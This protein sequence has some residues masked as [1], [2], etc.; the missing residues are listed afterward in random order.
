LAVSI[1]PFWSP[2]EFSTF[3]VLLTYCTV[4]QSTSTSVTTTTADAL[5]NQIDELESLNPDS[6]II[7]LGDLNHLS[8]NLPNYHQQVSCATRADR[9]LDKCYLKL[10]DAYKSYKLPRLGNSDHHPI[11]L[12]PKYQP[13]SRSNRTVNSISARNWSKDNID[14][15]ISTLETTD[16]PILSGGDEAGVD[17]QAEILTSYLSFCYETCIPTFQITLRHDKP[18]MNREIRALLAARHSALSTHDH[19]KMHHIKS[20]LQCKIRKAKRDYAKRVE[21]SFNTS[22]RHS[23]KRLKSMLRMNKQE[24]TCNVPPDLLNQF[25]SRFEKELPSPQ[26]PSTCSDNLP[27]FNVDDVTKALVCSGINKSCGPDGI[28]GKLLR[29]AAQ[30]IAEPLCSLF[31]KCIQEGIFPKIW[32][33]SNIVPV[34]KH[35]QASA[36]KDY[37]PVALT[38]LV[39]KTFEKLLLKFIR[40]TLTDDFQFAYRPHRGTEDALAHLLDIVTEHLDRNPRG[41]ARCLFIDFTSAFNTISPSILINE[42]LNKGLHQNI[43][44]LI[45]SFLT[46]RSQSVVTTEGSSSSIF[47]SV[48][49]PQGCVLSPLLFTIYIQHIP[50]PEATNY[51]V[52]KYADDIVY[53]ELLNKDQQST[54]S[55]TANDMASWCARNELVLNASK[56]KDLC[57][58]NLRFN[59][60]CD[61]IVI[62]GTA[63]EKVESFKY[64]GT[65]LHCKLNFQQNTEVV[66]NKARKRL[67]IMKQLSALGTS[68]PIRKMCYTTFIECLFKYHI[69]TIYGH[70][71]TSCCKSVDKVIRLAGYLAQ[72]SFQDLES[73]YNSCFKTRC[74]RMFMSEQEPLFD[75]DRLPSGR[76]RAIKYRVGIRGKCFRALCIKLLNQVL[77]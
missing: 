54:L 25:Y 16:W 45:Y 8:I 47:T 35:N 5:N 46:E 11:V 72:C 56:T 34:P 73:I 14:R 43:V 77:F 18:W 33:K 59:P 30:A 64:L 76:Y 7:V 24:P 9:T 2:R 12:L 6:S 4:F 53:I 3:T 66:V 15:L 62:D 65:T 40:P 57:F 23:W 37:R 36:A 21:S 13:L 60:V 22:N 70:M 68:E 63:I 74:L 61:D 10:K 32:K 55:T 39:A 48:G 49:T 20:M 19:Q 75:L 52:L 69:S 31:N 38:S 58:S 17:S 28:P 67:F 1:Q 42:L 29:V 26:L 41:F 27:S 50:V 44:N 71:S 51:H